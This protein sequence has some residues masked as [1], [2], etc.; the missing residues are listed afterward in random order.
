MDRITRRSA[1]LATVIHVCLVV[2]ALVPR[3]CSEI[4]DPTSPP[5]PPAAPTVAQV[6]P[7][8]TTATTATPEPQHGTLIAV[9]LSAAAANAPL[10]ALGP[11]D[12]PPL[13]DPARMV[14]AVRQDHAGQELSRGDKGKGGSAIDLPTLS[15]NPDDL[16]ARLQRP[17]VSNE[18]LSREQRML[19]S[20]Q[21]FLHGRLQGQI[22]RR[23]RHLFKDVVETRLVIELR[24]D[25]RGR[26]TYTN[27]V[28][29]SGSLALDRL[30]GDWL[31]SPD[32]NLPP[33]TADIV[34]PF[35]ITIRR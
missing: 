2:L 33:I 6:P 29:S 27:L 22:D 28:N 20:A 4:P 34:Y 8:D 21:E 12:L 13:P 1:S 24:V 7:P 26:L 9:P 19:A 32:V 30:I 10:P 35:L 31:Q 23:W 5:P 3:G 17:A 15:A 11:Q 16:I 18:T 25:R 14:S